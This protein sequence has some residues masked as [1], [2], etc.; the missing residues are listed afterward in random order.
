MIVHIMK[1][2]VERIVVIIAMWLMSWGL[3]WIL[4]RMRL[5][6]RIA[7]I[8]ANI[9]CFVSFIVWLHIDMKPYGGLEIGMIVF[10]LIVWGVCLALDLW[11]IKRKAQ[12]SSA[13]V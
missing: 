8:S 9:L 3:A 6:A 2:A 7:A 5:K 13:S 1:V 11:R 4:R 12:G 10:G